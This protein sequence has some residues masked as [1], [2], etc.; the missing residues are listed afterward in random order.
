MP[1]TSKHVGGDR[2][3]EAVKWAGLGAT[4]GLAAMGVRQA[5][6]LARR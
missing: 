5:L 6:R 4:T 3:G 1:P 2:R